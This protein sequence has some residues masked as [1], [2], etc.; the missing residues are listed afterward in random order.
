MREYS[1]Y[2]RNDAGASFIGFAVVLT[3]NE[4]SQATII[5][6]ETISIGNTTEFFQ[7]SS[8]T[9]KF[10]VNVT[11]INIITTMFEIVVP[12]FRNNDLE[13]FLIDSVNHAEFQIQ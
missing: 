10:N 4:F 7:H 9:N 6:F 5:L 1:I 2:S 12:N 3:N 13:Y 11:D 8:L